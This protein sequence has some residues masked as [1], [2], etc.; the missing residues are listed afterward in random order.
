[1]S[2][3]PNANIRL[4][5]A[6]VLCV[7]AKAVCDAIARDDWPSRLY[8]ELREAVALYEASKPFTLVTEPTTEGSDNAHE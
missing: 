1:M 5:A 6:D 7:R 8:P 4:I 3:L 2:S